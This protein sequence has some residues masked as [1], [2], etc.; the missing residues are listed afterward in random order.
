MAW[1]P[2]QEPVLFVR[3]FMATTGILTVV[4]GFF[5]V[6]LSIWRIA[7]PAP[8]PLPVPQPVVLIFT[9]AFL[10]SFLLKG[11]CWIMVALSNRL[12][13]STS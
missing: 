3:I 9:M 13:K 2:F 5:L 12:W 10:L 11:I 4:S 6:G 7:N 1:W 8:A